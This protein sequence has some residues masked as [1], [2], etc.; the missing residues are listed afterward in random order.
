M[1]LV[2]VILPKR[3]YDGY[4]ELLRSIPV[5]AKNEV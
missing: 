1:F 2:I 3:L 4:E 5:T